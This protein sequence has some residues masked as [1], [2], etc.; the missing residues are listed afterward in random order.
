MTLKDA[1]NKISKEIIAPYPPGVPIVY[2]GEI[3]L[4]KHIEYLTK[5]CYNTNIKVYITDK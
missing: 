4:D 1:V 2:P 3:I 5:I